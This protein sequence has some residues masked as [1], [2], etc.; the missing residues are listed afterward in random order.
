MPIVEI[1]GQDVEFPDD[2]S[3]DALNAAVKSAANQLDPRKSPRT[4]E[5]APQVQAPG[6]AAVSA[7][8]RGGIAALQG[9]TFGFADEALGALGALGRKIAGNEKP[10]ADLYRDQRDMYRGMESKAREDRPGLTM[11][12]QGMAGAAVPIPG[13]TTAKTVGALGRIAQAAGTG[14]AYGAVSGVGQSEGATLADIAADSLKGAAIGGASGGV[15]Q[16][17][18]MGIGAVGRNVTS[19]VSA[20]AARDYAREKVGQALMRDV[21]GQRQTMEEAARRGRGMARAL[22]PEARMVDVGGQNTR[23][24][25]DTLATA[26]GRTKDQVERA[27]A[28]RQA[29]AYSRISKPA[30]RLMLGRSSNYADDLAQAAKARQEVAKPLYDQLKGVAFNVDDDLSSILGRAEDYIGDA[31]KRAKVRG[32]PEVL[33]GVKPGQNVSLDSLNVLKSTLYDAAQSLKREG[34]NGAAAELLDLRIV[35]KNKIDDLSPKDADGQSIARLADNAWGGAESFRSSIEAGRG[36]MKSDAITLADDLR[37]LSDSE[38]E[39]FKIGAVQA[40]KEM[41]GSQSGQTK[42]LKQWREQNTGQKLRELFGED[43]RAFAN[44][45]AAEQRKKG[46][47]SVGRGSQTAA[48][49]QGAEDLNISAVGDVAGA[50]AAAKTSPISAAGP[51]ARLAGRMQTPESVRDEMGSMLLGSPKEIESI[52]SLSS[53][54]NAERQRQ[55]AAAGAYTGTVLPAFFQ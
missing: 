16:G 22:G 50:A 54:L 9:P 48:R 46:L 36:A 38:A 28:E 34:K 23:Q 20:P 53:K 14:A 21:P 52:L 26:P 47:E 8:T 42:L 29:G 7:G 11:L 24:L 27:I 33:K 40:I 39:G 37:G 55:A 19:R 4:T 10:I 3:P 35:L 41:A 5:A 25:L 17:V 18:G 30:E 15:V 6:R 31:A 45:L 44:V 32:Q 2:M 43:Y 51:L 12:T 49:L 13:I 1:Y